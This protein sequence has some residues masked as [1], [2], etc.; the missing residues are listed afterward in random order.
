MDSPLGAVKVLEE[1]DPKTSSELWLGTRR[2]VCVPS[3][4]RAKAQ[5]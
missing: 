2:M 4:N 3:K 5:L 1:F